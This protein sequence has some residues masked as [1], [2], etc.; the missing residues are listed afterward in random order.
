MSDFITCPNCSHKIP[1]TDALSHQVEEKYQSLIDAEKKKL[2]E[3]QE[4]A[5]EERNRLITLS[6]KRIEEER[7]KALKEAQEQAREKAK[8]E[9]ELQYKDKENEAEELKKQN[10][11]FQEQILEMNKMLRQMQTKHEQAELDLQKKIAKEQEKLKTE[12]QKK[13]DE[14][15]R[16]KYL[17]QEKRIQDALRLADDYKR[18]LE[19]GSQQMQGEVKE[20]ELELALQQEFPSDEIQEVPK[21]IRGADIIQIVKDQFGRTCGSIVWESKRTKSWS[22]GWVSKLKE[23]QRRIKAECAVIVTQ[24]LPDTISHFGDVDGVWV[25]D[26]ESLL[27]VAHALRAQLLQIASLKVSAEGKNEKM[28]VLY[29]YLSGTEFKQRVEGIIE[30]FDEMQKELEQEKRW[31]HKKWAKQ[32]KHMRNV[33]DNTS[34]MHGDLQSIMGKALAPVQGLE[35]LPEE[36]EEQK[37]QGKEKETPEPVLF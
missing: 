15:H 30:A 2:H 6:K 3:Q 7:E 16:L 9:I 35:M 4:K 36:I 11:Q 23:D 18:K 10:K 24:A 33:I 22:Q 21:G 32:E 25:T 13:A 12:L 5:E 34:G 28:E 27:G 17:E 29:Q 20:L 26:Y 31:F 37:N 1:L 14:E 19:Q 8:K